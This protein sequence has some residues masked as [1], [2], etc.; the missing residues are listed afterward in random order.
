MNNVVNR[1]KMVVRGTLMH[2]VY[3]QYIGSFN[4]LHIQVTNSYK[5][6]ITLRFSE[7]LYYDS[8]GSDQWYRLALSNIVIFSDAKY[9][10][11]SVHIIGT[12]VITD[13]RNFSFNGIVSLLIINRVVPYYHAN[14]IMFPILQII[15]GMTLLVLYLSDVINN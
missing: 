7:K 10:G 12:G 15:L 3:I 1:G 9:T 8:V 4:H 2:W 14:I 13:F 5:K 6:S 11:K